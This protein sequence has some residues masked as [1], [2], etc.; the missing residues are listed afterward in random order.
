MCKSLVTAV[1]AF[2]IDSCWEWSPLLNGKEVMSL[3]DMQ[4]GG[5]ELGK[6]MD[7]CFDFQLVHPT[8][9]KDECKDWLKKHAADIVAGKTIF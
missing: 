4:K 2:H 5:P 6:Y 3:L 8:G 7:A 9:T 1:K